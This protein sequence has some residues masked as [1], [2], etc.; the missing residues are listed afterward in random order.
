VPEVIA[1]RHA[2]MRVVGLSVIAN[3]AA[4]MA[5]AGPAHE[6]VLAVVA[7]AAPRCAALVRGFLR[8][9]PG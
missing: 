4:G 7:A 2:G 1:A 6:D 5:P 8:R 9:L 3:V